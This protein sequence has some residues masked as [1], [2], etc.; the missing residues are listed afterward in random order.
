[1][2][3]PFHHILLKYNLKPKGI[4]HVGAWDGIEMD[5]YA[6]C[7]ITNVV[8]IEAQKSIFP[9]LLGRIAPYPNS[10]AFNYCVSDKFEE[11]KFNITNN[12]QSSSIL[13]LGTHKDVHP[14]VTVN[15]I[16]ILHTVTINEI[17]LREKLNFDGY[18]FV[19]MDIQGAE[20]KA[21]KGMNMIMP[22]IKAF[23][24]EVNEKELYKGCA[25]IGEI[26]E[27]LNQFGFERVETKWASEGNV[28]GWG[29]ALYIK[30][31]LSV[32]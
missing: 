32:N 2:L 24:L 16:A 21:L 15:E 27:Y 18:D 5:D 3:I 9:T 26:D 11:I 25:L 28:L 20:L 23:Y 4:L 10:H 13:E 19:N 7:G 6:S 12:G 30:T 31:E 14:E 8:F 17:F 22:H 29:D 1:M